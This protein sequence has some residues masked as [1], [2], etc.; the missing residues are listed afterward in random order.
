VDQRPIEDRRD[1]LVYTSEP[2]NSDYTVIGRIYSV[3]YAA[4]S[5]P[6][7]DFVVRLT[8]VYP[9]GRSINVADGIIRASARESHPAPGVID[10]NEPSLISPG[11]VYEYVVDMWATGIMFKAGHRIRVHVTSSSFPRWDRN[12]NTGQDPTESALTDVAH[13]RIFHDVAEP[14]RVVVTKATS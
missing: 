6:D 9:D 11:E 7:T 1:V 4:S 13:Q 14:S 2:L 8:D 5:A 12:L 10:P 3:L